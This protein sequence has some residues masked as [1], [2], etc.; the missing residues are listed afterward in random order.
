M[1]S[2]IRGKI[3]FSWT[4]EKM[5]RSILVMVVLVVGTL[6]VR[7]PV[8][9]GAVRYL[10]ESPLTVIETITAIGSRAYEYEY[11]F[12]NVD[13]SPIW[14]FAVYTTFLPTPGT[15]SNF[16][17]YPDWNNFMSDMIV[18]HPEADARNLDPDI[19]YKV[20]TAPQSWRDFDSGIEPE[21]TVSG[22]SFRANHYD[23]S[24]KY[25]SYET[26]ASGYSH[27]N[28]GMKAAV[29]QTVP[30]PTTLLLLGLGGLMVRR[31]RSNGSYLIDRA[32]RVQLVQ[33]IQGFLE[34]RQNET[35]D[36]CVSVG[37]GLDNDN[38][39]L[40]ELRKNY[41]KPGTKVSIQ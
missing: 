17:E 33:C 5:K 41:R 38:R 14:H 9:S 23:P 7:T 27:E 1:G 10:Y 3:H 29:G 15:P 24:P 4:G 16:T 37:R 8:A 39:N 13:T 6:F 40:R 11:S 21:Q 32:K 22:F 34:V 31:K 30:E 18:V 19:S 12:T 25:Y 26:L 36:C 20:A 2:T 28:G 35:V